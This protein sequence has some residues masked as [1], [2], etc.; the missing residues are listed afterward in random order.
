MKMDGV[1]IGT[2][3]CKEGIAA[4]VGGKRSRAADDTGQDEGCVGQLP[5]H[6]PFGIFLIDAPPPYYSADN[7]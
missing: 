3:E 7:H 1:P 6:A 5:A 2:D 4:E